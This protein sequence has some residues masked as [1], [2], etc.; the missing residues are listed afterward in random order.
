[1]SFFAGRDSPPVKW[2]DYNGRPRATFSWIM[3][4]LSFVSVSRSDLNC[5][6]PLQEADPLL[7]QLLR[8]RQEATS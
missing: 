6:A 3:I 8:R 1:M 2:L 7:A 4:D 5:V